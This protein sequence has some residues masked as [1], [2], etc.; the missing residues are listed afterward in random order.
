[1]A[2]L[3][4][5]E[6]QLMDDGIHLPKKFM[7]SDLSCVGRLHGGYFLESKMKNTHVQ[8]QVSVEGIWLK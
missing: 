3:E 1:M 8:D 6:L 2:I 7:A 5:K 4:V